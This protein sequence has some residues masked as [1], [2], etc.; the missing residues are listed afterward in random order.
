MGM[1]NTVEKLCPNCSHTC[2]I[3]IPQV[4]LGFGGFELD[5][6]WTTKSLSPEEKNELADYVNNRYFHCD[7]C[8]DDFKIELVV[9]SQKT[10]KVVI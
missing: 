10:Q 4:V 6:P 3:Q 1:Y 7:E 8:G 9:E 5:H 2:Q